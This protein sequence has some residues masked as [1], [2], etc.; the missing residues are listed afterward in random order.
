MVEASGAR[1]CATVRQQYFPPAGERALPAL[2][3]PGAG[4]MNSW[5]LVVSGGAAAVASS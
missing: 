4:S 5:E 2:D 1:F 3:G